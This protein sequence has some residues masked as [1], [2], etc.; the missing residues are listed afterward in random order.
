MNIAILGFGVVGRGVYDILSKDFKDIKVKYILE[1]DSNKVK[2][3]EH[4]LA[5]SFDQIIHDLEVDVV[6]ELIGGKEIAYEFVK[7]AITAKK[8]VV[9]ANKALISENFKTLT[10]M[11]I[12]HDVELLYEASVGGAIILLDPLKQ[13][14]QI[15]Q[16]NQ[17]EGILNGSTNF[18]LSKV[19]LE[20][21]SITAALSEALELGYLEVGSDDDMLGLDALRKIN[22]LSMIAYQTYIAEKDILRVPLSHLTDDFINEVKARNCIIKYMAKS[23][24]SS[25]VLQLNVIPVI[26]SKHSSLSSINYEEN[27]VCIYGKYHKKQTFIG[28]GAGRYP[29]ASAVIYD[30]LTIKNKAKQTL[31]YDKTYTVNNDIEKHH[32]L[33]KTDKSL[34][35]SGLM[36]FSEVKSLSGLVCFAKIEEDTYEKL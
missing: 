27:I 19:F 23:R 5:S 12:S 9:T 31:S 18:V 11:A 4:L 14:R 24:V 26:M 25:G 35:K 16:I 13:I 33:I 1:K 17:I 2:G 7:K 10:H 22:I 15:N 8:H 21:L 32:F 30:L 6:V 3:F 29:T 20:D 34:Y 36:T 28:Q